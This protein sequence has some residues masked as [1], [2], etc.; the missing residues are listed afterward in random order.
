MSKALNKKFALAIDV[1]FL[2]VFIAYNMESSDIYYLYLLISRDG[3]T[4]IF[5]HYIQVHDVI[6]SILSVD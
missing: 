5:I 1:Y 4:F 6:S 3:I 2:K